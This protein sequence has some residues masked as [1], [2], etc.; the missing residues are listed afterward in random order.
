MEQVC[1][2]PVDLVP[3]TFID[4]VIDVDVIAAVTTII[5]AI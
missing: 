5:D 2:E 1:H 4:G 3:A